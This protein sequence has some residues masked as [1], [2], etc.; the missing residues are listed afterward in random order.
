MIMDEFTPERFFEK[1]PGLSD[2]YDLKKEQLREV[3]KYLK[4]EVT[5]DMRKG[6]LV[7]ILFRHVAKSRLA[8]PLGRRRQPLRHSG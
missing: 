3:A 4:V 5:S 7:E 6:K 8:M 2:W 1:V